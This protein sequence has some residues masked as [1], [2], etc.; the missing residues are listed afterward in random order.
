MHRAART[1][2]IDPSTYEKLVVEFTPVIRYIAQR[3]A[4]RLPP[5]LD[6]E[7]LMHAGVIGLMDAVGKYDPSKEAKFRTYAEFRIRGA[8][9]DEIR[10]LDWIPRSVRE[11]I[12]VLQKTIEGLAKQLGRP[13]TEEEIAEGL[14]LSKEQ[15]DSFLFQTRAATVLNLEDLGLEDG[16]DRSLLESL[17]DGHAEDPLISL[18]SQEVRHKLI[19]AIE[20]LPEKERRVIALYY[21]EEL[22]MKEIGLVLS[23][24]ESRVCQLHTQAILRLK[25]R[26]REYTESSR[27]RV[28]NK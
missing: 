17:A 22:T 21:D 24:T 3:L 10:S 28:K 25:T 8:M 12:G 26:L 6:V 15:Y 18:L 2:K 23:I 19:E 14:Q 1:Q 9:L 5:Y 4:Y 27:G 16:G 20:G 13:P 11:K 7:D